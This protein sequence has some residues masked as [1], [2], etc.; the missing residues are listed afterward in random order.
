V[1]VALRLVLDITALCRVVG[2]VAALVW[3]AGDES[4]P[5]T[6]LA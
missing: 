6:T 3:P 5:R 4:S 1:R 2:A